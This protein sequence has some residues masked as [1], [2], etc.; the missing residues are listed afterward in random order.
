[1]VSVVVGWWV[2]ALEWTRPSE[3]VLK[4]QQQRDPAL[5]SSPLSPHRQLRL[6]KHF[7]Q[8]EPTG[9][10]GRCAEI[11]PVAFNIN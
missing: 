8:T 7:Y 5:H 1:M 3:T 4:L 6:N 11:K 9:A 10:T 2:L